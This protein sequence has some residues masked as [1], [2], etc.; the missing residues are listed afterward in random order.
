[1]NRNGNVSFGHASSFVACDSYQTDGSSSVSVLVGMV[2]GMIEF[3][4]RWQM[5][6]SSK[7]INVRRRLLSDLWKKIFHGAGIAQ[8]LLI[9]AFVCFTAAFHT[10]STTLGVNLHLIIDDGKM[11]V[12]KKSWQSEFF[13]V[14]SIA[15]HFRRNAASSR[16]QK[17][18][19]NAGF[20][21]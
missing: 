6:R 5:R 15:E 1:M 13:G 20:F 19:E 3:S 21:V 7:A 18:C 4:S 12:M 11:F 2:N 8:F 9:A 16:S 14:W 10:T 17:L